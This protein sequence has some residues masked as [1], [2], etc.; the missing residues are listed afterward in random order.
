MK[1]ATSSKSTSER[2][3]VVLTMGDAAGVGP[4]LCLRMLADEGV[5]AACIPVILGSV[6][7]LEAA[8]EASGIE[9]PHFDVFPLFVR[10]DVAGVVD[11]EILA[12]GDFS[13]GEPSAACGRAS[14]EYIR[15]A[16][17]GIRRGAYDAVTTAPLNKHS[18][19]MAGLEG[20]GHTEILARLCG[21]R[22]CTMVQYSREIVVAFV[23]THVALRDVCSLL[24]KERVVQTALALRE[25]LRSLSGREPLLGVCALNPHGGEHGLMG[26]EEEEVILPAMDELKHL[27][28]RVEGPLVPDTAFVEAARRRFDGYVAMYHDQGH[29]PFKMLSFHC[30]VNVTVGLPLVRTSPDHGVAYDIAWRGVADPG[31][32]REAVLL[33]ATLAARR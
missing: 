18:L 2:P 14:W 28:M 4:E 19:A 27:G 15:A 21:V 22:R 12:P 32:M 5:L 16:V 29:I 31:S 1:T 30:G 8:A 13:V 17:E 9:V 26:R 10:P 24:N 3:V 11:M 33:A 7:V 6:A 23:T 20:P 25:F